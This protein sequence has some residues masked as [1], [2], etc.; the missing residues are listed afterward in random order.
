MVFMI[1]TSAGLWY[2]GMDDNYIT[3]AL[4]NIYHSHIGS[5]TFAALL[6]AIVNSFKN[7]ADGNGEDMNGCSMACMCMIRCCLSF[8]E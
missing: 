4:K 7:A 1:A 3:T 8:L 6:V 2:Y 5:F